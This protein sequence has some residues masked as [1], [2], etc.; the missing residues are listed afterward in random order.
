MIA[1]IPPVPIPQW[2]VW[3]YLAIAC[4][5]VVCGLALLLWGRA[6][7]RLFWMFVGAG[8]GL[9]LGAPLAGWLEAN[10]LAARLGAAVTLGLLGVVLGPLL[11]ALLAASISG[12]VAL[13]FTVARYLPQLTGRAPEF[14][15]SGEGL[16]PYVISLAKYSLAC[17]QAVWNTEPLV[18]AAVGGLAAALPLV[19]G[20]VRMRLATIFMTSVCGAAGAV[21][22]AAWAAVLLFGSLGQL[23][24]DYWYVLA[25]T[26]AG[27]AILGIVLQYRKA[28]KA[29]KAEKKREGEPPDRRRQAKGRN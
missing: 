26:A 12:G 22:G 3:A 11:W 19:I 7:G 13:Y 27:G 24:A 16:G 21:G 5:L 14:K 25:G 9:A 15:L 10:L 17:V 8:A 2:G 29:D 1:S 20:V 4:G 6:V 28:L 23:F 18:V